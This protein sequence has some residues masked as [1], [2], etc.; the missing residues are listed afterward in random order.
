VSN[1]KYFN[2]ATADE[3][4]RELGH[5][6]KSARLALGQRQVELAAR[7]GVSR[8]TIVALENRGQCTLQSLIHIVQ[9][10]GL[11]DELATLFQ[12]RV[13]SIAQMEALASAPRVRASKKARL[14]VS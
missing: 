6:V 12:Q 8:G 1:L 7:A 9:A 13:T 2:L 10:L 4:S 14:A 11:I 5:R 3:I